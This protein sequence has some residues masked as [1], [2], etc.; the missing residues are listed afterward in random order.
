[1]NRKQVALTILIG[2]VLLCA[3][4]APAHA[5]RGSSPYFQRPTL[6]PYFE[7]FRRDS[8]PLG[9][10]HSFYRPRVRLQD[11]LSRQYA[12]LQRQQASI[13]SLREQVSQVSEAQRT[14]AV[15]PTGT[16][17]V[18]MNYSHYYPGLGAGGRR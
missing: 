18:F 17:S 16:G 5:Q 12:D 15:R 9:T 8:A 1:M 6:S 14:G 4:A 3:S 10:Y 11:T 2:C 13:R 7:L